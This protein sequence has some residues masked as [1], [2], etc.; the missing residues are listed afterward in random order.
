RNVWYERYTLELEDARGA[1]QWALA[2]REPGI[3]ARIIAGF[4]AVWIDRG[5]ADEYRSAIV[6]ALCMLDE[7]THAAIAAVLLLSLSNAT[8]G[9]AKIDAARRAI[10]LFTE[11]G[12]ETGVALAENRFAI[13][14]REIGDDAGTGAL[15]DRAI[16]IFERGAF[17]RSRIMA[18]AYLERAQS[19][20]LASDLEAASLA[21]LRSLNLAEALGDAYLA[22]RAQMAMAEMHFQNGDI[23][24]AIDWSSRLIATVRKDDRF[25]QNG[26][27][28]RSC[29]RLAAGDVDGAYD[30]AV[31][32]LLE[33]NYHPYVAAYAIQHLATVAALR[34]H[35]M[36]A[37][38]LLGYVDAALSRAGAA[39]SYTEQ[40]GYEILTKVLREQ[41][42]ESDIAR[43]AAEGAWLTA[44]RAIELAKIGTD[45][46][47]RAW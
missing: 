34:R 22:E 15:L 4:R 38:S 33:R 36:R 26:L 24:A 7:N 11:A 39:R 20:L 29:Y 37:A 31:A 12:D 14:C 47:D 43:Y 23:V 19:Y 5:F 2:H 8:H 41:L 1:L 13:G 30:D 18:D 25:S 32:G 6:E 40:R 9:T 42:S 10:A 44:V 16:A 35:P 3:A 28:N 46:M 45:C 21:I 17:A 27:V